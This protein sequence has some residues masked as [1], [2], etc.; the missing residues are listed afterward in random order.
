MQYEPEIQWLF[1]R[2]W[3]SGLTALPA[4]S[5]MRPHVYVDLGCSHPINQSLT[6]LCRVMGWRGIA[7]DANH[8]YETDWR[9]AGFEDHFFCGLLSDRHNARFSVHENCFT[10]RISASL[11]T[12]HPERWG[13]L[14]TEVR[15]C[16][17]AESVLNLR[18]IEKIDLLVCDLEGHD[19]PVLRGLDWER[20]QPSFVIV[21]HTAASEP[22]NHEL[23]NF[24]TEQGYEAIR[25]FPANVIFRRK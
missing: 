5:D 15:P 20:H 11:E 9:A 12:D 3:P 10:S 21:E 25:F 2:I 4:A 16:V 14:R 22:I 19:L 1:D 23:L 17:S 13:I 18:N 7:I 6:H 24:V 8:D